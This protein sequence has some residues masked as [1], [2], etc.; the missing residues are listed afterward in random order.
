MGG[1]K[2]GDGRR[3]G[4][5]RGRGIGMGGIGREKAGKIGRKLGREDEERERNGSPMA[6]FFP[7]CL[8]VM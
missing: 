7:V 3:E 2:G 4:L 8:P 5:G 1:E 6:I